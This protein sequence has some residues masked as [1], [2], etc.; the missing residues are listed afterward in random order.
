MV[1]NGVRQIRI[2][3]RQ[4]IVLTIEPSDHP[5]E[6]AQEPNPHA[7]ITESESWSAVK[8]LRLNQPIQIHVVHDQ[9]PNSGQKHETIA[10]F[11]S[12]RNE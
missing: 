10:S 9:N 4:N 8:K 12:A 7:D 1:K 6:D 11:V 5:S 3:D 2:I